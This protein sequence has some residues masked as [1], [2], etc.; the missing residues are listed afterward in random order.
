MATGTAVDVVMPQMGVSV[1]E[2]TITKWLK[3]EGEAIAADE[4]AARDLDRQGRHRGSKPGRGRART[5]SSSRRARPS[6]SAPCS[7]RS[8]P[9]VP[10]SSR[11]AQETPA[12]VAPPSEPAAQAAPPEPAAAAP[13]A[14]ATPRAEPAVS[15]PAPSRRPPAEDDDGH[16][17][18]RTFVSPV[19]ARIA[20]EHG[21]DVSAIPAPA[22]AGG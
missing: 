11:R 14:D 9:R 4:A 7:P 6:R 12:P 16:G 3:A 18:G 13:P 10:P 19:V 5:A 15:A 21:V 2:G 8:C 1:S 20:A 17:D 22:V